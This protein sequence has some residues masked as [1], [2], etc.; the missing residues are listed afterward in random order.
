TLW[1]SIVPVVCERLIIFMVGRHY[2]AERFNPG[3]HELTV[4]RFIQAKT[5]A[6]YFSPGY[7]I[8]GVASVFVSVYTARHW[9][10]A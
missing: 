2:V 1:V 8:L 3:W 5:P 10:C 7:I 4:I 6:F 9:K